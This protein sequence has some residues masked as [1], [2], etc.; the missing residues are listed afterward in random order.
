MYLCAR[1]CVCVQGYH[2]FCLV[3]KL[4]KIP[5][6]DWRCPEC[7]ANECT[8]E[9]I[10]YGFDDA[11]K[12]YSLRTFQ[13]MADNFVRKYFDDDAPS[14]ERIETEFWRL[15]DNG[16]DLGEDVKVMLNTLPA[17]RAGGVWLFSTMS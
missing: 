12:T 15:V 8:T 11:H 17:Y 2:I 16:I 14:L 1:V 13:E 10:P 5:R 9:I 7:L 4:E 3:P 6:G